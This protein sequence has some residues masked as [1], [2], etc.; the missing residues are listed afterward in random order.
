[1]RINIVNEETGRV[2]TDEQV[3]M[4]ID[5]LR[6][7]ELAKAKQAKAER[8]NAELSEINQRASQLKWKIEEFDRI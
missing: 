3:P 2:F 6:L 1:M 4:V 5:Y 7:S 8:L